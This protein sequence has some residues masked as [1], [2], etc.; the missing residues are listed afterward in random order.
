MGTSEPTGVGGL[1]EI[2]NLSHGIADLSQESNVQKQEIADLSQENN[3][4]KQEITDLSHGIADLSQENDVQK[5][6]IAN[7]RQEMDRRDWNNRIRQIV[8][9]GGFIDLSSLSVEVAKKPSVLGSRTCD[10]LKKYVSPLREADKMHYVAFK[11]VKGRSSKKSAREGVFNLFGKQVISGLVQR[12]HLIPQ[13]AVC[14]EG[15][16]SIASSLL[17]ET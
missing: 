9:F 2:A 13:S 7:L 15:G 14:R 6:E 8:R 1:Q 4:Q 16:K 3:V 5:Q 12:S 17:V 11:E 10:A